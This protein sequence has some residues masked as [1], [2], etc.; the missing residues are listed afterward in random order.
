MLL[1]AVLPEM[2][3]QAEAA[4]NDLADLVRVRKE[5]ADERGKLARDVVALAERSLS[6]SRCVE[7]RQKK[8][9]E[10]EKA[11]GRRAPARRSRSRGRP[12]TS[13]I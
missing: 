7:E 6:G 10:V 11:L 2:R 4:G 8:Q 13:R 12:T 1:G 3:H 9:A 5:I